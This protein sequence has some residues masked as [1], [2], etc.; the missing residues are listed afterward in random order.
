MNPLFKAD[1]FITKACHSTL[2]AVITKARTNLYVIDTVRFK[3]KTLWQTLSR[4]IKESQII[5]DLKNIK[6][7]GSFNYSWKLFKQSLET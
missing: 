2:V 1:I 5:G 7:I 4:E 3:G 6:S